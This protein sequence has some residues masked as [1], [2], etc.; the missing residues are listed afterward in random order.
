MY[1]T[2]DTKSASATGYGSAIGGGLAEAKQSE[3]SSELQRLEKTIQD[4]D[5]LASQFIARV[6]PVMRGEIR[7]NGN[8]TGR[9]PEPVRATPLA[10]I[11][12]ERRQNVSD[13]AGR[14]ARALQ[15]VEL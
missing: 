5:G 11:I 14:L 10:N 6:S 1:D 2:Q 9:P 3:I 4:L 7:E 8:A 13:I 12:A 15:A